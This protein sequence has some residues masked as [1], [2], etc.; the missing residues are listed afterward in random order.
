MSVKILKN[1]EQ[2]DL[3]QADPNDVISTIYAVAKENK[4]GELFQNLKAEKEKLEKLKAMQQKS[5][6]QLGLNEE[7]IP[8]ELLQGM[9]N[10]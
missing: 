3:S 6:G 8:P 2:I 7:D 9:M 10:V 5:A 1:Q 4:L